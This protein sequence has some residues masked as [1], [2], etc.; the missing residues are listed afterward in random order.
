MPKIHGMAICNWMTHAT[1][2]KK[3]CMAIPS[4]SCKQVTLSFGFTDVYV[5]MGK[6]HRFL[7]DDYECQRNE[8]FIQF[9]NF[10]FNSIYCVMCVQEMRESWHYDPLW[11]MQWPSKDSWSRLPE[12]EL[13]TNRAGSLL[14]SQPYSV[15]DMSDVDLANPMWKSKVYKYQYKK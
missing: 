5:F 3:I 7:T 4:F 6:W 2:A 12:I 15:Q 14:K 9:Q 10:Q 8:T 11:T 13:Y 1:N